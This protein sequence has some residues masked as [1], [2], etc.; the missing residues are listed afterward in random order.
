MNKF[1]KLLK[2]QFKYKI[3]LTQLKHY[4][5]KKTINKVIA[6]FSSVGAL[7]F[8]ALML[9]T[10]SMLLMV[11]FDS[12]KIIGMPELL[13]SLLVIAG[14]LM[15]LVLGMLYVFSIMFSNKDVEFLSAMPFKPGQIF[16]SMFSIVY[17]ME[18]LSVSIILIPGF[19]IFG[20]NTGADFTF[21]IKTFII[22]LFFPMIPLAIA[23]SLM[24]LLMKA[25]NRFKHKEAIATIS[26]FV[27]ITGF[28]VG[29]S[30]FSTSVST[31]NNSAFM[32]NFLSGKIDII[33]VLTKNF[34]NIKLAM[35]AITLPGIE[36]V[37]SLIEFILL[38][39]AFILITY[40]LGS[41]FYIKIIQSSGGIKHGKALSTNKIKATGPVM[42]YFI[43]EWRIILRTGIYAMNGLFSI[44]L[45]PIMLIPIFFT[46][47]KSS[48]SEFAALFEQLKFN[49]PALTL[50]ICAITLFIATLNPAASTTISREGTE[51]WISKVI[52]QSPVVQ[53]KGK[54]LACLSISLLSVITTICTAQFI[55]RL[56]LFNFI[57]ILIFALIACS[58]AVSLSIIVDLLRPKLIWGSPT[59]AIKQ[60]ANVLIGMLLSIFIIAIFIVPSLLLVLNGVSLWICY[61]LMALLIIAAEITLRKLLFVTAKNRYRNI[62]R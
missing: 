8:V 20:V 15:V 18:L 50:G 53:I 35:K 49:L 7:I 47:S 58:P 28:M 46:S 37:L 2:F 52:P 33:D 24:L 16:L 12:A 54:F 22:L 1:I 57:F 11:I 62:Y 5:E 61:G 42:A 34:P 38:S 41:K 43:K 4:T 6:A 10:Y 32:A 25:T 26:G 60:N 29:N 40:F 17:I 59:E 31:Q 9:F 3:G 21:W 51:F 30:Y 36:G 39:L 44:V 27:L 56:P 45:G 55:L 23:T 14:Q 19:A 13:P 48:A